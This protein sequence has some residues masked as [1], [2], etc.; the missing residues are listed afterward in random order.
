VDLTTMHDE[1]TYEVTDYKTGKKRTNFATG[2]VKTLDDF[3]HDPQLMIYYF[4]LRKLYPDKQLISSIYYQRAGGLFSVVFDDRT[5]DEVKDMIRKKF[6][7]ISKTQAPR[8]VKSDKCTRVC[9]YGMRTFAGSDI[10]PII[11][12]RDNQVCRK[13][14][15]MTVCEQVKFELARKGM[16]KVTK[17]YT[18]ATYNIQGYKAPGEV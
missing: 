1:D 6:L 4:A 5:I 15:Y 2:K 13:G 11:E 10:K 8:L 16:D 17:E 9:E 14:S 3:K 18:V 7:D 12:F